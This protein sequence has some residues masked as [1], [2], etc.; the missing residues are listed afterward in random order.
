MIV[1]AYNERECIASTV[2]SLLAGDHPIEVIVVD[3]GSTDGTADIVRGL[4]LPGVRLIQQP[5]AGKP[6]ALNT[7]IANAHHDIIVMMDGDTVFE[8]STV[9]E[10]I[11]PFSD[12]RV[13][14]VAGNAKIANRRNLVARLQHIEYVIGFNLDRRAYDLLRCM[15]TVPGAVGAF[16]R[17]ALRQVGGLSSDTLAEDTDLTMAICASGWRVVYQETARAWTEAPETLRQLW[18]QRYRWSYGTVQSMWKHRKP[19]TADGFGGRFGRVA[20]IQLALFQIVLPLLAPLI[21]I[22]LI[23]GLFF[24]DPVTTAAAWLAILALQL[25]V[26]L[27]AFRLEREPLRPLLLMPLQQIV[28]RQLMYAVLIRSVATAIGG[29]RLRWQKMN[30]NGVANASLA[31]GMAHAAQSAAYARAGVPVPSAPPAPS[32]PAPRQVPVPPSAAPR[33]P[34][35]RDG[36]AP[37]GRHP[38][39]PRPPLRNRPAPARAQPPAPQPPAPQPR[40]NGSPLRPAGSPPLPHGLPPLPHGLPPLVPAAAA[41]RSGRG[42]R[43]P[44]SPSDR[45]PPVSPPR[46]RTAWSVAASALLL[47][48]LVG[49][50]STSA[51][52]TGLPAAGTPTLSNTGKSDMYGGPTRIGEPTRLPAP[53]TKS[54]PRRPRP[55]PGDPGGEHAAGPLVLDERHVL[56]RVRQRPVRE[57]GDRLPGHAALPGGRRRHLPGPDHLRGRPACGGRRDDPVLRAAAEVLR[58]GGPLRPLRGRVL[59]GADPARRPVRRRGHR[60]RRARLRGGADP[61]ADG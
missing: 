11:Q 28:Y 1:P 51:P 15:P 17:S 6:A 36:R 57:Q 19:S 39:Q 13:G 16:R 50:G 10:L 20:L 49:C 40:P 31:A 61:G 5:N 35:Q 42:P 14:A 25:V 12:P 58:D 7:G 27:Y 59:V 3:D 21:D 37:V 54:S 38:P 41:H 22:F 33:L 45:P 52:L 43:W 26:G 2:R 46:A 29:V 60:L 56:R 8:P 53:T 48:A 55:R 47:A 44:A 23:Y 4:D 34:P 30:R 18:R 32:V 9:R 24:L